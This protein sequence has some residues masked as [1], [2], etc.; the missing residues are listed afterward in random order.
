MFPSAGNTHRAFNS[1]AVTQVQVVIRCCPRSVGWGQ[2]ASYHHEEHSREASWPRKWT[3]G[4]PPSV[5]PGSET[6]SPAHEQIWPALAL[7]PDARAWPESRAGHISSH[8]VN[9]HG[10]AAG[11]KL[12]Y[13]TLAGC[14]LTAQRIIGRDLKIKDA[15]RPE[16]ATL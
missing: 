2:V 14:V 4:D 15:P 3:L 8:L 16:S 10:H 9:T 13:R 6:P 7:A 5:S 11:E 12:A 1:T